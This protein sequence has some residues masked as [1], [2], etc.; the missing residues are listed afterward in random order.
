MSVFSVHSTRL[1]KASDK[2]LNLAEKSKTGGW[3]NVKTFAMFY[4][5]IISENF[6]QVI[7]SA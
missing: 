7:L 4:K 1:S 5:K 2:R 3:S 6:G